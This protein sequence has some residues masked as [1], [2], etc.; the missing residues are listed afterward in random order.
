M[1]P[2]VLS[3]SSAGA[4]TAAL[5]GTRT[6]RE[7]RRN[8]AHENGL[9]SMSSEIEAGPV[10]AERAR[11]L[12]EELMP[13][14]TFAEA[15]EISGRAINISVAAREGGGGL[16]CSAMTTP[17]VLVRDAVRA[18]CAVPHFFEPVTMHERRGSRVVPFAHG[19]KWVDGSLFADIPSS[20][21]KQ[22][23]GVTHTIV[24]MVNPMARPFMADKPG[25]A[26]AS[27][28]AIA[29]RS[30]LGWLGWSRAWARGLPP[31]HQALDTAYR[32]VSQDYSGDLVLTP[33]KRFVALND[34][35]DIPTLKDIR[36]LQADGA[37]RTRARLNDL[38]AL[39][40]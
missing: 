5:I 12:V 36:A 1:L 27:L 20:V 7:L 33:S 37:A 19:K 32:L 4:V 17:H 9:V 8:H 26:G 40:A 10:S 34:L 29:R 15:L 21:V 18:S 13:D 11:D 30:A 38:K 2:K 31:M 6:E 28:A 14:V 35:L 39:A 22:R 25:L 24:S 16:V 23:Y 3:G